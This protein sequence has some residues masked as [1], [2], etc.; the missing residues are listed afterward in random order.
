[1]GYSGA[2]AVDQLVQVWIG[3]SENIKGNGDIPPEMMTQLR[4]PPTD[5][6]DQQ[7]LL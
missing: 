5:R 3:V 4:A 1:M 7:S 2:R 6:V